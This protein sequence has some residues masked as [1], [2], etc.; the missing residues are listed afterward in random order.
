M[1][2]S[3]ASEFITYQL[4]GSG[5]SPRA[6]EAYWTPERKAAAVPVLSGLKSGLASPHD[7]ANDALATEPKPAD[8]S[9]MPFNTSGKLFFTIDGVDYVATANIFMQN[10]MLLTAAHCI[11][12][13]QTGSLG[14]NFIFERCYTGQPYSERLTFKTCALKVNWHLKPNA[15]WDYGIAI[16]NGHSNVAQPLRYSLDPNIE[17]K[18]VTAMGYPLAFF[19]G[20]RMMFIKGPLTTKDG[21]WNMLGSKMG[22]GAS[23]GAWVLDDQVTAI[24]INAFI[25][26]TPQGTLYSG[27]PKFDAEFEKLYQHALTLA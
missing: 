27:S 4:T 22:P 2:T 7:G 19:D 3:N 6:V 5:N 25:A 17:G 10:N 1:N 18:T 24:G 14:T 20:H 15:E 9:K 8:M 21:F 16:L 26:R 11:Q 23:G 13:K 12:S